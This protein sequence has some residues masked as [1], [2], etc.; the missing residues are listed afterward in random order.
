MIPEH[1]TAV[2]YSL[3]PVKLWIPKTCGLR[4]WVMRLACVMKLAK[5]LNTSCQPSIY[6][7]PN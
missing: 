2:N 6:I 1:L 7:G 3:A 4:L 5:T